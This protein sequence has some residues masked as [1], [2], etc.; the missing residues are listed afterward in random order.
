MRGDGS[1]GVL[2][3]EMEFATPIVPAEFIGFLWFDTD[4]NRNTG[5]PPSFGIPGQDI[6]VEFELQFRNLPSGT[7]QLYRGDGGFIGDVPVQ[8]G[9]QTLRFAIPLTSLDDDDGSMDVAGL[10]GMSG[11][12]TD[13]FPDSGHGTILAAGW[14]S[15]DP[16]SGVVAP[17]GSAEVQVGLST[18]GLAGGVYTAGVAVTSNGP[19]EFRVSVPVTLTAVGSPDIAAQPASLDFGSLFVGLNRDLAVQ[20]SNPGGEPLEITAATVAGAGF[21]LVGSG[22]PVTVPPGGA[23]TRTLRFSP[24]AVCAPCAGS[25]SL[26]SNDPD[27]NPF[28]VP[29][30]GV[31]LSP[32]DIGVSPTSVSLTLPISA[33]GTRTL[34]ITNSGGSNLN[35]ATGPVPHLLQYQNLALAKGEADPRPGILGGAGPD[36]FGYHWRD[37]DAPGGPAFQWVDITGVGTALQL[38]GDDR[39][40]TGVPIGFA[41]PFYGGSFSTVN[42]CTNGFLS[43][44]NPSAAFTNS[45]LPSPG[46]PENLLAPFWGDLFVSSPRI[47]TYNDGTRFIVS[48]VN[49]DF[50]GSGGPYTFQVILYPDGRFAFQYLTMAPMVVRSTIGIQ[51]ATRDDGLTVVF[52]APYLHDSLAV[53][54]ARAPQWLTVLPDSGVVTP[55]GSADLQLGF[56]TTGLAGGVYTADVDVT[57]NDPDESTVSVPVTLNTTV[58]VVSQVYGGGGNTGAP[59]KNDY[60]ELFN[61]ATVA[62][63]V[64]GWSVQYASATGSTWQTTL[65]SGTIPAGGYYLIQEAAGA[66]G[67]ASLPTP[68]ASGAIA[69]SLSAGKVALVTNSTPLTGT[70]PSGGGIVDLV[71][72]GAANCSE[73]SPTGVLSNTTADFRH[74]GGCDDTDNNLA[75]FTAAAPAPRNSATALHSCQ[76]M[77]AM[78]VDPPGSGSVA[79]VPDQGFYSHGSSVQL[80]ATAVSGYHFVSW[81][82]GATGSTNPVTV[83]MDA[84]RAVVA[85][86]APNASG[87]LIVISQIYGGGGNTGA[88][89]HNDYIELFNRGNNAVDIS[90][91]SV[92]YAASAGST[93]TPTGLSGTIPAGGY[94][95]IQEAVGAGGGASL[96]TPNA[97]GGIPMSLSAGKVALVTNSTPLTGPCPSG[98]GIVDLVGYGA[99]NCSETGPTGV[100]SNTTADFRHSG[101]CDDTDN[102]LADFTAAAPAPRNSATPI[103]ICVIVAVGDTPATEFSLGRPAPNPVSGMLH[104]PF[105][106]PREAEVQLDVVDIQGRVVARLV[107]GTLP[108]GQ[109]E[110]MWNGTAKG[111]RAK[112]GVYF[113][114][115]QMPGRAVV[116][117][118]IIMR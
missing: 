47:Y 1:G 51:N 61:R 91:W 2:Q 79:R 77:L 3:V 26:V 23:V 96:P 13:W 48:W 52:N 39:T 82:G 80:T 53:K 87:G 45:P 89:Y 97:S 43:F 44:T 10:V 14:L 41:F 102:N 116:R 112:S 90:G 7:G 15:A 20:L 84:D 71:G 8:I 54:F 65:L 68:D 117:R 28:L 81:S 85:Q 40:A 75:D 88:P 29:L 106:L 37:S 105:A 38:V 104:V 50:F 19:G 108:S 62:V 83:V 78:T 4:R 6:G 100:L 111:G 27:E 72:Y 42:V 98:G 118:V 86:F 95:L 25:L 24:S 69:M 12:P 56:N 59:F 92:Q 57:S 113:I 22:F 64:A 93:W 32:P 18:A 109:H 58:P 33:T 36:Q 67:G 5:V 49:V 55:G 76:H 17:G 74:S 30:T 99:A 70:C 114:R 94:Y 35:F 60:I 66:G 9:A 46:A 73:T 110:V 115:L 11:E 31:G 21:A 63:S 34:S 107:E 16:D 103:R 101:G